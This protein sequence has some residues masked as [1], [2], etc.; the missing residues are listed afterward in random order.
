MCVCVCV[1]C[2]PLYRAALCS[3][4]QVHVTDGGREY[5]T[6]FVP[7][8]STCRSET[9]YDTF[10]RSAFIYANC[11]LNILCER[12]PLSYTDSSA[13]ERL[14]AGILIVAES[15]RKYRVFIISSTGVFHCATRQMFHFMAGINA[16]TLKVSVGLCTKSKHNAT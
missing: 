5:S 16:I 9:D 7:P 6:L 14:F 3:L 1:C 12:M 2:R 4:F 8:P 13:C 10:S 15:N 11:V